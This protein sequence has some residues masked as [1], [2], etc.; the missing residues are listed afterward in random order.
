MTF[1]A[2][3]AIRVGIADRKRMTAAIESTLAVHTVGSLWLV[4][5]MLYVFW[6]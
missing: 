5:C 2:V 6:M 4:A 1:R 3:G